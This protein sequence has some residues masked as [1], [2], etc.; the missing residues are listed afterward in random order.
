MHK[1][2]HAHV[3][4]SDAQESEIVVICI[5]SGIP[6]YDEYAEADY[7]AAKL[8]YSVKKEIVIQAG[9]IDSGQD[10]DA[11]KHAPGDSKLGQMPL[12]AES[13]RLEK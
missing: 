11:R 8:Y 4:V 6:G 12:P 13:M 2:Q 7:Y 3:Q 10:N 5:A 9:Q 1:L